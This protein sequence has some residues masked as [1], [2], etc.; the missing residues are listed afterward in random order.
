M[1]KARAVRILTVTDLLQR[2]G[3]ILHF[4]QDTPGTFEL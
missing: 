4:V 1:F 2:L 3:K